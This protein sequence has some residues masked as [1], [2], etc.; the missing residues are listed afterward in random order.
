MRRRRAAGCRMWGEVVEIGSS[1]MYAEKNQRRPGVRGPLSR[2]CAWCA[3]VPCNPLPTIDDQAHRWLTRAAVTSPLLTVTPPPPSPTLDYFFF[4]PFSSTS[5]P[6]SHT[7]CSPNPSAPLPASPSVSCPT[8]ILLGAAFC[9][10]LTLQRRAA[11]PRRPPL[12]RPSTS[13]PSATSASVS[14]LNSFKAAG[15]IQFSCGATLTHIDKDTK[16][17]IQGFT[18]KTVSTVSPKIMLPSICHY[19]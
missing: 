2:Q 6:P 7:P 9:Q 4:H 10:G 8:S 13:R 16:V 11:S 14:K 17:L 5:L 12:V 3:R 1:R 15:K 18:G 19:R